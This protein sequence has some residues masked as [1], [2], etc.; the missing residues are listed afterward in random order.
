MM[1]FMRIWARLTFQ[2]AV[3]LRDHDGEITYTVAFQTPFGLSAKRHWP[4]NISNAWLLPDGAVRHPYVRE[5][6]PL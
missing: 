3:A 2:K 1:T 5:W 4:F 6:K